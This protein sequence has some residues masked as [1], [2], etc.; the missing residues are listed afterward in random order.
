M[1]SLPVN[2]LPHEAQRNLCAPFF[3]FPY[4]VT[5]PLPQKGQHAKTVIR[6]LRRS[7]FFSDTGKSFPAGS[8]QGIREL[9]H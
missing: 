1:F 2:V 6:I 5:F 3:S 4:F 7:I 8:G 9:L